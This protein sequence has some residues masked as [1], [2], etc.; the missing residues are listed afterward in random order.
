MVSDRCLVWFSVC[1]FVVVVGLGV[2]VGVVGVV[3]G[4]GGRVW[5]FAD[6]D[7]VSC[8]VVV[9]GDHPFGFFQAEEED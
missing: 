7:V 1:G 9:V 4:G 8:V 6:P 2:G 3:V 5:H